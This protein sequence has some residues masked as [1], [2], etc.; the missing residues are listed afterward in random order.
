MS[1][2]SSRTTTGSATR[3]P[4]VCYIRHVTT[5]ET[6]LIRRGV[7]GWESANTPCSPACLNA[8]LP[9]PPTED[10][11]AAMRYRSLIGW[12]TPAC[13]PATWRARERQ[14]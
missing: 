8:R 2:G 10:E 13:N 3:L 4:P 5:G 6:V 1:R 14:S 12:K 7:A 11:I 9:R